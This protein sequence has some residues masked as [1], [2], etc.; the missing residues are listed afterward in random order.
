MTKNKV[1]D[2][3]QHNN[4]Q[5]LNGKWY[6]YTTPHNKLKATKS[7]DAGGTNLINCTKKT[8]CYTNKNKP[9]YC[10]SVKDEGQSAMLV[11]LAGPKKGV[12]CDPN[13]KTSDTPYVIN[14]K[15]TGNTTTYECSNQ[16]TTL[17]TYR[18]DQNVGCIEDGTGTMTAKDC[19]EN[20]KSGYKCNNNYTCSSCLMSE[21][22][23]ECLYGNCSGK[24]DFC[25]DC[26]KDGNCSSNG[27]CL[28]G[29][30]CKCNDGYFGVHC[31]KKNCLLV[32]PGTCNPH[33]KDTC[34][35]SFSGCEYSAFTHGT[36]RRQPVPK[37]TCVP[38]YNQQGLTT[39]V[40]SVACPKKLP[41]GHPL[42]N[43]NKGLGKKYWD[44][45]KEHGGFP[46]ID[47]DAICRLNYGNNSYSVSFAEDCG[48][49]GED[50]WYLSSVQ[51][52]A[53]S[54]SEHNIPWAFYQSYL[55]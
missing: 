27:E 14:V 3:L 40:A 30:V 29:N 28:M 25:I 39:S 32:P 20:C 11:P 50:P 55:V 47:W 35:K 8:P 44:L 10:V 21:S 52:I 41:Y 6:F 23:P 7:C 43:P 24:R 53:P 33:D 51:C 49:N 18:C 4:F 26:G 36:S 1:G 45:N 5:F 22:D 48:Q 46:H 19:L 9:F 42:K 38:D 34:N 16:S 37:C 31:E 2:S 15:Q 17:G 54:D 12:L 13:E